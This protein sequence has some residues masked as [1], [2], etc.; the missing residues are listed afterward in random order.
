[1]RKI[2]LLLYFNNTKVISEYVLLQGNLKTDNSCRKKK[3]K[4]DKPTTQPVCLDY[5]FT[6]PGKVHTFLH[7]EICNLTLYGKN[8][9]KIC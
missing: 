6:Q 3:K 1:M 2:D 5:R 7:R 8:S 4:K 9:N